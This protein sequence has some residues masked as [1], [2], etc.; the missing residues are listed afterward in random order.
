MQTLLYATWL[1]A[2]AVAGPEAGEL[3]R[4]EATQVHMG[5]SFEIVLYAADESAANRAFEL[6]FA[7]IGQLDKTL[8]DY[9]SGSELSRLSKASPTPEPVRVSEDLWTILQSSQELS[10][11]TGGAFD[12]TVGPLTKLW[13][14][15]RAQRKLPPADRLEQARAAVGFQYMLLDPAER[16]VTLTQPNMRLDLGAI[17]K[18]Y[19]ADEALE[20][21]R[22][23][24]IDRALVNAGGGLAFGAPPPGSCGWKVGAAPR[25]P[26]AEPSEFFRLAD[27]GMATSGDAWQF[28]E[29]AGIGY[30]HII[31]PRSGLGLTRRSGVTVVAP[32]GMT[33]DALATAATVLGPERG[34]EL[35]ESTAGAAAIFVTVDD[36]GEPQVRRSKDFNQVLSMYQQQRESAVE[37]FPQSN[38]N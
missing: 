8:S 24:G 4:Y 36:A 30:S 22:G 25:G 35:I 29:L 14:R 2:V 37:A 27:C 19:A 18:G 12:V 34:L 5:A 21:L 20:V 13:R 1:M 6:A 16:T 38:A 15:T 23:T 11:R 28:V 26:E 32:D 17:A 7:R 10:R 33:A 3:R 9:D 31:D